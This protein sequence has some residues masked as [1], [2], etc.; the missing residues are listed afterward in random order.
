MAAYDVEI[1][2][3]YIFY[4]SFSPEYMFIVIEDHTCTTYRY[5]W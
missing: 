1:P 3:V 2:F 5:M 4:E